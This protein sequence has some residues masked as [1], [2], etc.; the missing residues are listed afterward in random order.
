MTRIV[1]VP[2][3][4]VLESFDI[5]FPFQD[6]L[7]FGEIISGYAVN[8]SVFTG[9]DIDP[10]DVL[11]G[12]PTV[13]ANFMH[14]VQGVHNGLPGVVYYIICSVSG[15]LGNVYTKDAYLSVIDPDTMFSG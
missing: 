13:S 11:D 6:Q 7:L 15:S 8:I 2:A 10:D 12:V 5:T 14:M 9:E 4:G 1:Q 3:K